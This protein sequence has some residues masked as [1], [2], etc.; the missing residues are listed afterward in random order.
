ML[1]RILMSRNAVVTGDCEI[2]PLYEGEV[3][4]WR[5]S[6]DDPGLQKGR[7][8][9]SHDELHRAA[10]FRFERDRNRFVA[11]RGLLRSLLAAYSGSSPS[12]IEFAY[13]SEGKPSAPSLKIDFN[14]S[15]SEGLAIIGFSK[16]CVLGL[17]IEIH[18]CDFELQE[19]AERNFSERE[20]E[21]FRS[22]P[23]EHQVQGFFDC[24]TRKEAFLKAVGGGLLVPLQ[25]FDVAFEVGKQASLL[26]ARGQLSRFRDWRIIDLPLGA[27]LS[28]A[29]AL[30][31]GD[32]ALKNFVLGE[33]GKEG[34]LNCPPL[35]KT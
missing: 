32:V 13:S 21:V 34:T 35:T 23:K 25:L 16:N 29:L 10:L 27:N 17:D 7:T 22:L 14:V 6:L 11:C 2:S 3:H 28:S 18:R 33:F 4:V 5:T 26:D 9:L 15:H 24:W 1:Y 8:N 20:R 12:D 31:R 30:P 19:L